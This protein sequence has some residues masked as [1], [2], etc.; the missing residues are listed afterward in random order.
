M[1]RAWR[2]HVGDGGLKR[3][4]DSQFNAIDVIKL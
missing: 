2:E 3:F 4:L 1:E